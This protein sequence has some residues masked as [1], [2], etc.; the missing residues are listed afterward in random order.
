MTLGAAAVGDLRLSGGYI[1]EP[2]SPD[3]AAAYL[4]I[5]DTGSRSDRVTRLTTDVTGSVMAMQE[6]V[7]GAAGTMTDLSVEEYQAMMS[8]GGRKPDGWRSK[9][10]RPT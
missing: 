10:E 5:T 4:T 7:D 8:E 3:V 1:P 2:A 9:S 6:N